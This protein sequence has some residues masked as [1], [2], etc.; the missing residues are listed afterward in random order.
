MSYFPNNVFHKFPCAAFWRC[1]LGIAAEILFHDEGN[2]KDC[3]EKPGT[4]HEGNAQLITHNYLTRFCSLSAPER[5]PL[6]FAS[7]VFPNAYVKVSATKRV[8][9]QF[10]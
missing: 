8:S 4:R 7:N 5:S 3:S 2:E 10:A 6:S 1:A 9:P